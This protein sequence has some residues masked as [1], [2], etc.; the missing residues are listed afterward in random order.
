MKAVENDSTKE[1]ANGW[2]VRQAVAG[3]RGEVVQLW[4]AVMG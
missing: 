2:V 4:V 1:S 3:D